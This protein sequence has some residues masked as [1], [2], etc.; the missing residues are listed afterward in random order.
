MGNSL[1]TELISLSQAKEQNLS[2]YFT[3]K[4]C[5]RGHVAARHVKYRQCSECAKVHAENYREKTKKAN[6]GLVKYFDGV[7][8]GRGHIAEKYSVGNICI[9]CR[10]ENDKEY[11]SKNKDKVSK[12][13]RDFKKAHPDR[14]NS[15]TAKRRAAKKLATP[16]WLDKSMLSSIRK[17]YTEAKDMEKKTGI[18][19]HVDHIIP[20]NGENVSGLHVPWNLQVLP[21]YEN[22]SKSNKL[23]EN[24]I[25]Q[26][27]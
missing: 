8:C 12:R 4:P 15:D 22:L 20:L 1:F 2:H 3:G 21:F 9:E 27:M 18:V 14:V 19:H 13:I 17:F 26:D 25:W 5:G 16:A 10:R 24:F 23:M 6:E 11:R 7:P